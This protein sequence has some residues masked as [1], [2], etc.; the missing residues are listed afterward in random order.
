MTAL[1]NRVCIIAGGGNGLGEATAR[2]LADHGASVVV[3][4]SGTSVHGEG[5]DPS[6]AEDVADDIREAGGEAMAHTGDLT[7]FGD[8]ADLVA[9]TI[10]E[11]GRLD[12]VANFVGVLR[13]GISYK[14]SEADWNRVIETNLTGQFTLLR[15]AC[16]HWREAAGDEGFERQRSYLAA[17]AHSFRGNVGQANYAAS[18]GGI[19]GMVR[20]VAAEMHRNDVRVN[21]LV[22]NAYTRM[23]ETVP[24]EYRP[25]T[26]REM[27]PERVA[28]FVAYLAGDDATDIT[29]CT[30][31]AGGDR[32]GVFSDPELS[33]VGV[34]PGGW[35]VATLAEHFREDVA[36]EAELTRTDTH[37]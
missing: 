15:A 26:R 1:E 28:A 14:L 20:S 17:C 8:A 34:Q 32:V 29:G 3:A 33:H 11:Y 35:D 36:G 16:R 5:S 2:T 13:D 9:A 7:D 30:L 37:F 27:P 24:E 31:Y 6:V 23:T 10:D 21:A 12:S 22:P 25:Y 19:L 18:K 4:D